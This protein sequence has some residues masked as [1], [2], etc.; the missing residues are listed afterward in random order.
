MLRMGT[1]HPPVPETPAFSSVGYAL[2]SWFGSF[3]NGRLGRVVAGVPGGEPAGGGTVIV[4]GTLGFTAPTCAHAGLATMSINPTVI[5][6][7]FI[8]DLPVA[9][10]IVIPAPSAA[11]HRRAARRPQ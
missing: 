6:M 8:L 2:F 10:A 4:T 7:R 5:N 9:F 3:V 11:I 1:P